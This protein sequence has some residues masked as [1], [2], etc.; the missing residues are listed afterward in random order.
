MHRLSVTTIAI[1]G[2]K[3]SSLA[4]FCSFKI[5]IAIKQEA[6][7]LNLAPSS[8]T[9][10]MM[11]MGDALAFSVYRLRSFDKLDFALSHPAGALGRR[12]L[13]EVGDIMI[14][15]DKIPVVSPD[16]LLKSAIVTISQGGLGF[17]I[18]VN[19]RNNILGIFTDG[20]LRRLLEKSI[21]ILD[22]KISRYMTTDFKTVEPQHLAS[23]V[24]KIMKSD[25]ISGLPVVNDDQQ[26]VG[27]V[28]FHHLLG[29]G[30][31]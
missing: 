30:L 27:A 13:L 11:A 28:N 5:I 4:D 14:T 24:L 3:N 26:L 17:I 29:I 12:L 31:E 22:E 19:A 15:G 9:T 1:T 6:C 10:V 2:K 21:N 23:E 8:S 7:P 18:I 25:K 20:D 16:D